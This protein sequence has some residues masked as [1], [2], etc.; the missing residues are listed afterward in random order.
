MKFDAQARPMFTAGNIH[1]DMAE[2]TRAFAYGGIG[3]IC[4]CRMTPFSSI[5]PAG[6]MR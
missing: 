5:I 6:P 2:R 1:Y 4:S 3:S